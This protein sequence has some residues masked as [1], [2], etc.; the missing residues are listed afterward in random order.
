MKAGCDSN[1]CIEAEAHGDLVL[2]TSTETSDQMAAT[3]EEWDAFLLAAKAG[4]F[5]DV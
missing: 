5:D 1:A 3:R 2:V 4:D